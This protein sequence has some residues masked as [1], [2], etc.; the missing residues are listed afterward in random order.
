MSGGR[1]FWRRNRWGLLVLVPL[2]AALLPLH[3]DNP[4]EQWQLEPRHRVGAGADGS[5]TFGGATLR[6][7]ALTPFKPVLSDGRPLPIPSQVRAWRATVHISGSLVD[8][9]FAVCEWRLFDDEGRWFEDEPSEL[10]PLSLYA[11]DCAPEEEGTDGEVYA[12]FLLPASARPVGL[13]LVVL[14]L[15]PDYAWLVPA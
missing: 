10:L 8:E 2:L 13:Q 9:E 14:D 3:P 1:G 7:T 15:L 5:V 12:H 4:W 6:L 11:G